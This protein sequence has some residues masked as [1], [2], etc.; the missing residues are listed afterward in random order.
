VGNWFGWQYSQFSP[1]IKSLVTKH[2]SNRHL[3]DV[4]T[5]GGRIKKVMLHK[6][7]VKIWTAFM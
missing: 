2:E 7:Y 4:G 5:D 3:G 1:F 6:E